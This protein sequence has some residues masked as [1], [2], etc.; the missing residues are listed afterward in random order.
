MTSHESE[1]ERIFLEAVEHHPHDQ[2]ESFVRQQCAGNTML[3]QR[4][5]ILLRAHDKSNRM[6]DAGGPVATLPFAS[7]VEAP[8]TQI[9]P[10]KLLEQIGSGGMGAVYLAEQKEPVRRKVALKV[11]KLGMDTQQVVARFEAERQALAMMNHPNIARVLDAGAT[12]AGRPYFVMELVKGAPITEFCDQQQLDMRER[13]KLFIT[14]C[15]AVQHA[16]H[17]GLIH[18]D[19][20]PGNVLVEL[21]DIM[22]VAKVIDFGVAKAI[23]QSLTEKTLHTGFDQMVGTPLYMS[24]EQAGRSSIDVDTRSDIYSLGVL[25][26]EILTGQTPFE[27]DAFRLAGFDE[28]RK[29][30]CE[31]DPPRPSA[32]VSTL[33]AKALATVSDTRKAESRK[34]SQQLRGELDWIVMKALEKDR[35]LRYESASAFAADLQRYLDDEP[36]AACPPSAMYRLRKFARRNKSLLTT[37]GLV[38]TALIIGTAVSVWQAIEA[39]L[40]RRQTDASL[41]R[42][43]LIRSQAEDSFKIARQA[44]EAT[45][46]RIAD[47]PRLKEQNALKLRKDLLAIAVPFYERLANQKA[48]DRVLKAERGTTFGRLAILRRHLRE[49]DAAQVEF[50]RMSIV[51]AELS[52]LFPDEPEYRDQLALSHYERGATFATIGNLKAA[53]VQLRTAQR[54]ADA[55]IDG[56]P[57]DAHNRVRATI[58]KALGQLLRNIG[59]E[60]ESSRE[61]EVS[62]T[63]WRDLCSKSGTDKENRG[64]LAHALNSRGVF[65]AGQK[66]YAEAG[67]DFAAARAEYQRLIIDFPSEPDYRDGLSSCMGNLGIALAEQGRKPE[68]I[69]LYQ[70][71][72]RRCLSLIQEF[73]D[74]PAYQTQ[75]AGGYCNVG[76][77]LSDGEDPSLSLEYFDNAVTTLKSVLARDSRDGAAREFL[78]N[79]YAS[80]AKALTRLK[81]FDEA[82]LASDQAIE[83]VD[84]RRRAGF[85]LIK[86]GILSHTDPQRAKEEVEQLLQQATG[87]VDVLYNAACFYSL[88]AGR[89]SDATEKEQCAVRSLELLEKAFLEKYFSRPQRQAQLAQD[90][91][92]APLRTRTDFR[93]FVQKLT[94]PEGK[95]ETSSKDIGG[96][97]EPGQDRNP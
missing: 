78:A 58:H 27:R 26:Y 53:E 59:Q 13:L 70:E 84:D 81:R 39:N 76:G 20:K 66:R 30:I 60:Q 55:E 16:H 63:L 45:T 80:K 88:L 43:T 86:N 73:P 22:P 75:L 56:Q 82:I 33:E 18:R 28:M 42:E 35:D 1:A 57:S 23:G 52:G 34:L 51:F 65:H 14:V 40:A 50:E 15:Q 64:G 37:V 69:A 9:G 74:V 32:R 2:Q 46:N 36:V 95:A 29:M 19:I 90:P 38:G 91:D 44:L 85:I 77:L 11:I 48:D 6:L 49:M 79:A 3:L 72:S 12:D 83:W 10:Y 93:D 7:A 67:Q 89:M 47:D 4:V 62:I 71:S 17:K 8:G 5:T 24:P 41:V 87:D 92:F 61:Y 97:N 25:L 31:V 96:E 21:H 68:A 54:I 94:Q